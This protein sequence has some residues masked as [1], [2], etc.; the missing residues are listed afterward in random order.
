MTSTWVT[1][2]GTVNVCS[3]PVKANVQ[4]VVGPE[5]V[6]VPCAWAVPDSATGAMPATQSMLAATASADP[7]RPAE[8][9]RPPLVPGPG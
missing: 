3:A 6:Q 2:L 8:P 7:R 4:V 5:T 9:A 1:P